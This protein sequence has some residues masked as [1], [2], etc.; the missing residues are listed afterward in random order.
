MKLIDKSEIHGPIFT[1]AINKPINSEK[2]QLGDKNYVCGNC[3]SILLKNIT[4]EIAILNFNIIIHCS[5]CD[6]Y[7]ILE[8]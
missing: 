1:N 3:G 6:K 5:N 2:T 7:N 8:K 4:S